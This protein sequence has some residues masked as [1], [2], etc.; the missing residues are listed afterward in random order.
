MQSVNDLSRIAETLG[1]IP[2][3]GSLPGSVAHQAGMRYG[4]VIVRVNG[5]PTP[6]VDEYL[7]ARDS[8]ADGMLV[9]FV[10]DGEEIRVEL[11]FGD[12]GAGNVEEVAQQVVD[13]RM[14]PTRPPPKG[15]GDPQPN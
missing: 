15:D 4:D 10:R 8:R 5:R 1:G 14:M 9:E 6:N 12:A 11:T 3:W 2:V 7:A 13:S